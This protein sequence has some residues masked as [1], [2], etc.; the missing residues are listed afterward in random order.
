MKCADASA[1]GL[2]IIT[3]LSDRSDKSDMSDNGGVGIRDKRRCAIKT[4]KNDRVRRTIAYIFG[5]A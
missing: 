2:G 5:G 4:D 3:A 1:G